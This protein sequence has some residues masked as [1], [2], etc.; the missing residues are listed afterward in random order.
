M[1]TSLIENAYFSHQIMFLKCLNK[2]IYLSDTYMCLLILIHEMM[3]ARHFS[4]LSIAQFRK[5]VV[6]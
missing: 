6:P 5:H 1:L 3:Y 4:S 2:I